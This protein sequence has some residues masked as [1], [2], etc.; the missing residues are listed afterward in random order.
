MPQPLRLIDPVVLITMDGVE[1]K[2]LL[3][4]GGIRRVKM[5]LNVRK[6]SELLEQDIVDAGIP[7]LWEA[8]LDKGNLTPETFADVLPADVQEMTRAIMRLIGVSFPDAK[9]DPTAA[10]PLVEPQNVN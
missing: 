1:R 4:M 9:P 3:S 6:M 5:G 2:F 10:V 7:L 8:L